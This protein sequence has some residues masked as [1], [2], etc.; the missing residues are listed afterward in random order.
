MVMKSSLIDIESLEPLFRPRS[1]AVIGASAAPGKIGGAALRHLGLHG[2]TGAVYA[3][4]P[5]GG[6]MQ[7]V[8]AYPRIGDIEDVVDM[9]IIAVPERQALAAI[10]D[11]AGKGVRAAVVFTAG[12]AEVSAEGRQRQ[13]EMGAIAAAAGMRILG[14]NCLGV[15][16]LA[17]GA[18]AS[19]S[20]FFGDAFG[21]AGS[22]GLVSQSG[23]FGGYSAMRALELG[24]SF[25]YWVTSGNE[26]DVELSDGL[27]FLANDGAT[28]V[29]LAYMEG[30]RNGPKF[31]A[32]LEAVR[33]A[34][35]PLI[36][37]K[38][39]RSD[40]GAAAAASHTAALAGSDEIYDAV[41]RQYGVYRARS[42][43]EWFD[44]AYAIS[45]GRLPANNRVALVTA[46]G[47][48]GVYMADESV[49]AGLDVAPLAPESQAALK[50]LVPFAGTRNPIDITGQVI[51]DVAAFE[52]A[53]DIVMDA[54]DFGAVIEFHAGVGRSSAAG[55]RLQE[56]W[57]K[58]RQRYPERF[59]AVSGASTPELDQAYEATGCLVFKDPG[60][61]VRAAAAL[62]K[63]RSGLSGETTRPTAL[64]AGECLP[65]GPAS[66]VT[67]LRVLQAF[68]I[69]TVPFR[70]VFS[71]DEACRA[72]AAVGCPAV[73]KIVSPDIT[74][75]SDVGGVMLDLRDGETVAAAFTSVVATVAERVP[76]ARIDGCLIAPMVRGGIETIIGVHR[77][78][79]F[80][81][82]V[83]FGLGG[84]LVEVT[85]DVAFRLA[86]FDES[87]AR[88]MI[89]EIRAHGVFQGVR[90]ARP[91]D[92]GSLAR[93]LSR[94]SVFAATH[95]ATVEA[96][97]INPFVV[98][99]EG[100]GSL[101]LDA[102]IVP[103][104]RTTKIGGS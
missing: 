15:A 3:V 65:I 63:I 36:V 100:E 87:E 64:E 103:R 31:L 73:L 94:L 101:A 102:V 2:F 24:L 93:A 76:H 60:R 32:A 72:A 81:P 21:K 78:P 5:K 17:E 59:I 97:D 74:H 53:I 37:L 69:P 82:V 45:V 42:V 104:Q 23:A 70:H 61:A 39:G 75:K 1:I 58:I 79:V 41:F 14:P 62:A 71:A 83:M 89:T 47:G 13:E 77:D 11:C 92:V 91:A 56:S 88:R 54:E 26:L 96:V 33:R 50:A 10:K 43:D 34:K 80:G 19:F 7:G 18:V 55:K 9:A 68:G 98:L 30:C 4:N 95:A 66:E 38:V 35:K 6:E 25:S 28:K 29:I 49:A 86:P 90:G 22:I 16:N 57:A 84:V 48:V 85:R 44:M 27:A 8:S 51:A 40:V 20:P 52:K 99:P 12:F 67:A 46:S